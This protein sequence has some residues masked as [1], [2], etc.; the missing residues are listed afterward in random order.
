MSPAR[1]DATSP[2]VRR[3]A[4][5][6]VA[7]LTGGGPYAVDPAPTLATFVGLSFGAN[8]WMLLRN[9]AVAPGLTDRGW[10]GNRWSGLT[11]GFVTAAAILGVQPLFDSVRGL[12]LPLLVIGVGFATAQ[13]GVA[14]IL[15][16]DAGEAG[17]ARG[18]EPANDPTASTP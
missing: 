10:P 5:V 17:E 13:F 16:A 6:L 14:S 12:T 18:A 7:V 1:P 11:A 3:A 9:R 4:G 8:A 15:D 2:A